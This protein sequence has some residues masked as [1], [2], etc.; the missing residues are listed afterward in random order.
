MKR[1]FYLDLAAR[2]LRMPVGTDLVLHEKAEHEAI[3]LEGKRLGA[4]MVEAAARYH[5]PLAVPL[6]DLTLEKGALLGMLGI[7]HAE[8][9]EYHFA[10]A[11]G[12]EVLA[13]VQE[14]LGDP[15]DE[16]SK[17]QVEAIR[18]VASQPGLVPIGMC[19]GPFSLM[20]KLLADPITPV[21]MAGEGV[22]GAEDPDVRNVERALELSQA[23]IRRSLARQIEAGAKAIF[24]AEPAANVAFI[25]PKQ[26][27][28]GSEVW[29]R[30]VMAPNRA[31][32]QQLG[33]AGVDLIFHCCGEICE[34][35]LVGFAA[36]D[37]VI[38]SLGSSRKLWEDAELMPETTVLYGNLPTKKFYSDALASQADVGRM[39][40][41][42]LANMRSAGHPFILG[43]ECDVL[44]VP[45]SEPRIRAKVDVMLTCP[46]H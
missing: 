6:M 10:E 2:G 11:I 42:L 4:V 40:R 35:M 37:P 26:L 31:L 8:A 34:R 44:S 23:I 43:S 32:R 12:P 15:L 3:R 21:Y 28:A 9:A 5:T 7:S 29:N 18:F 41:E 16:R 17:A 20:T 14:H 27:E 45:G 33:E 25:S 19:I 36:L 13:R 39:T 38:L 24:L 22:S 30:F 46:A 1:Q